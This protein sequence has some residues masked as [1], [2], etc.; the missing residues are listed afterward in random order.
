LFEILDGRKSFFQWDLN[1]KLIIYDDSITEVHFCNKTDDCAL[2][3]EVFKD[4]RLNT[5][6]VPN[7]LLQN[8]WDIRVYAVAADH[9]EHAARFKVISRSKPADYVYTETEVK[10]FLLLEKRLDELEKAVT[11]EGI[12]QA[13]EDYLEANPVEAGATAEEAA[14]IAQNTKD[15][16]ALEAQA[17]NYALKTEIPKVDLTPYALKTEIPVVP[18]NVSAF[19]NDAG[20]MTEP[21]VAAIV[22][23]QLGDIELPTGGGKEWK[24]L[25]D[26]TI[27]QEDAAVT[28]FLDKDSNGNAF[29]CEEV[30]IKWVGIAVTDGT[31]SGKAWI[32][33]NPAKAG[34]NQGTHGYQTNDYFYYTAQADYSRANILQ[35]KPGGL[36]VIENTKMWLTGSGESDIHALEI[37]G[38]QHKAFYGRVIVYGR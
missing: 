28:L 31:Q 37:S 35:I 3:C 8:D 13:V 25:C 26:I 22:E 17:A 27:P 10:S 12:S 15:I 29:S 36:V 38:Y 5:V 16:S 1:Q 33:I 9:T 34:Y 23:D 11:V 14:Q 6:D 7:I 21:E 24:Q 19:A 20:Y 4:G 2:V 30:S 32:S 18:A